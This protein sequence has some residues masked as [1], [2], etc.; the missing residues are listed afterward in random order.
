[1]H[2]LTM[3]PPTPMSRIAATHTPATS[4][5]VVTLSPAFSSK[6]APAN[7]TGVPIS[8]YPPVSRTKAPSSAFRK[9]T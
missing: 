1:M 7:Q 3:D 9:P 4:G 5:V 8:K 6:V 2:G